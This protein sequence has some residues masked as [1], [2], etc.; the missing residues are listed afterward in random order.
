MTIATESTPATSSLGYGLFDADNHYYETEDAF[1]RFP[2]PRIAHRPPRWI[3]MDD[4]SRRLIFGD[5]LNRFVGADHTFSMVGKP[6]GLKQGA[7]GVATQRRSDLEPVWPEFQ[8]RDARL[9]R[10]TKQ[11]VQSSL[12]F[13]TFAVSVESLLADDIEATY[14]NLGSFN[15]WLD[16]QWGFDHEGRIYGVPLVS[17]LAPELATEQIESIA[18]RGAR[19]FQLRNGPVG[20]RSP[21]DRVFDPFW[22]AVSEADLAV[23]FHSADS[24]LRWEMAK[25]WG[26]GNVNIP[27]RN[28]PPLH[29]IIGGQDRA[30]HDTVAALIYGGLFERFPT[31]RV[32]TV[33]LGCGWVAPLLRAFEEHGRG[34]LDTEPADVLRRNFWVTPFEDEDIPALAEA[35]GPDRIMFGSD[36]PHTDGLAEPAE[37]AD[38]LT[39]FDAVTVRKIMHDNV[40]RLIEPTWA[41]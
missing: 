21:A 27:A 31:L 32:A 20:G 15:Q 33:E 29:R 37:F 25:V 7:A 5:R 8:Q 41:G 4:G 3:Q 16:D 12:F 19:A 13:P 14:A 18:G 11:G 36:Y 1:L 6:G 22:R 26:W 9:E 17:M 39:A 2:D 35:I 38:H 30:I 34:G 40:R 10:M 28:I 23:V 24:S